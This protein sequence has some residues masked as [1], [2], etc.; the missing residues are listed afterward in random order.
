MTDFDSWFKDNQ[1][2]LLSNNITKEVA[3]IIWNSAKTS[4]MHD[5]VTMVNDGKLTLR[6]DD[7]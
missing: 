5:L 2:Y 3:E 6:F 1:E 7:V 4:A